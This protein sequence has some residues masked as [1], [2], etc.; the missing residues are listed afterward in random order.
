M[1]FNFWC[2]T[3]AM[4]ACLFVSG[5]V[6]AQSDGLQSLTSRAQVRGWEA[7]GRIDIDGVGF[8]TGA[9][10]APDLVL[11]AA[12]CTFSQETGA[13]IDPR[14]FRFSAGLRDGRPLAER[15]VRRVVTHPSYRHTG[16]ATPE[17]VTVDLALLRLDMP[18]HSSGVEPFQVST[19][20]R[21]GTE[22]GI[23]SYA[24]EREDAPSL[25]RS[26]HVLGQHEGVLV[27]DC[28]VNFGASGSPVF[29]NENGVPRLV[30]VVSAMSEVEGQ[31]V[32]LGMDLAAPLATLRS[33]LEDIEGGPTAPSGARMISPG[34]TNSIGAL[35]LRP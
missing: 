25:E 18:I 15:S 12:H 3:L 6:Q 9:L 4:L 5:P 22:V 27:M 34:D 17:V 29:R 26:C 13:P 1:R 2:L 28:S 11:T 24:M 30:S 32:A 7:V 20:R 31:Q 23:V 16:T 8:C 19:V 14:R 35:F 33:R 10:I 21:R